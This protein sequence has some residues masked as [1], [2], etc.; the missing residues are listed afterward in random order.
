MDSFLVLF[1]TDR[2]RAAFLVETRRFVTIFLSKVYQKRNFAR[3]LYYIEID[4]SAQKKQV[5]VSKKDVGFA[6]K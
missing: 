4:V 3:S 2:P 6:I 5:S 1:P